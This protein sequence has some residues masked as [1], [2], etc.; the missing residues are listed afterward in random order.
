M[1]F[2]RTYIKNKQASKHYGSIRKG[3]EAMYSVEQ[4]LDSW[5]ALHLEQADVQ[6]T[7]TTQEARQWVRV[8]A[9]LQNTEK[10]NNALGRLYADGWVLGA[11]IA[12]YRVGKKLGIK[13]ETKTQLVTR[14]VGTDWRKWKPGNRA[15]AQLLK[16]SNGLKK[17]L[18]ARGAKISEMGSTTLN[19][20]GTKLAD[21]L[22]K[23][24]T[25]KEIARTL[26]SVIADPERAVVIAGTEMANAVVQSNM[27]EYRD[28]GVE[29]LEWLVS[30][31]CDE[32][33]DN[34]QQSPISIDDEW[35]NGDAP[36]HPNCECDVAP[37][38]VDTQG[39]AEVYGPEAE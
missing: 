20:I 16:P 33:D 8:H 7:V 15:A 38:T 31:P 3:I 35:R 22:A 29:M 19:R 5:F 39:W 9:E 24:L 11:D 10:L 17:L 21:G 37:Y 34:Y 13:K 2:N 4:I 27:A 32:C 14:A 28:M 36:V 30:D 6:T 1:R 12:A 23:G 26:Y 25:R 18:D